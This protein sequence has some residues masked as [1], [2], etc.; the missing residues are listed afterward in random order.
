VSPFCAVCLASSLALVA[1]SSARAQDPRASV[2][3]ASSSTSSSSSASPGA[4]SSAVADFDA[5]ERARHEGRLADAER[6]LRRSLAAEPRVATAFNLGAVLADLGRH[7]EASETFAEVAAGAYGELSPERA[8][9]VRERLETSRAS[10]AEIRVRVE[11]T[12]PTEVRI[13]GALHGE[14]VRSGVVIV[15]VDPG[16]RHV[17]VAAGEWSVERAIRL[18][19]GDASSVELHVPTLAL[20]EDPPRRRRVALSVAGAFVVAVGLGLAIGL[21]RRDR[22]VERVDD[23]VWGRVWTL[24]DAP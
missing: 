22:G 15:A 18:E 11:T 13:D 1:S 20:S 19:P 21:A 6:L 14:L 2:A 7:R 5:A 3:A 8:R 23:P 24:G 16:T 10:I 4:A 12:R 9:I 17:R